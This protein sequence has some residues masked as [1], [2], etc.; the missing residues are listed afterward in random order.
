MKKSVKTALLVSAA[1]VLVG[2]VTVVVAF[3][4]GG[5]FEPNM[6]TVTHTVEGDIRSVVI[7]VGEADVSILPSKT[8]ACYAVCDESDRRKYELAIDDSGFLRLTKTDDMRWYEHIGISTG[9]TP[10]VAL[11]LPAGE[12]Y[13]FLDVRTGNGNIDCTDKSLSF[14]SVALSTAAGDIRYA[15]PAPRAINAVA[16]S[17]NIMLS[18]LQTDTLTVS[19][20]SGN[21]ALHHVT[22]HRDLAAETSSGNSSLVDCRAAN[23]TLTTSSGNGKLQDVV[24][25][26]TLSV[27]TVSGN[28]TLDRCDA[29]TLTLTASSGNVKALLLSAML[30]DVQTDSGNVACPPSVRDGGYC[31]IRTKSGNIDVQI[32]S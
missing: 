31:T 12:A 25:T 18:D 13:S 24:A 22:V 21:I 28:M 20:S 2:C 11:Y 14:E 6:Q 4:C 30:F 9:K 26:E 5:E 16:S 7:S 3:A 10:S 1:L 23:L 27:K 32:T 15:S 8:N 29:L 17:G 19:A